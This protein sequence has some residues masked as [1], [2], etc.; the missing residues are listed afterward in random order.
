MIIYPRRGVTIAAVLFTTP[1]RLS[2]PGLFV[3]ATDTG[4]GKTVVTCAIA[5]CLQRRI[6]RVGV[7]KP[8]ATGCRQDDRGQLVSDDA[9]AL[10]HFA[11]CQ[12]PLDTINPIRYA[13]PLAP[14]VAAQQTGILP[15]PDSIIHSLETIDAHSDVVLVEGIGGL[16]VPLDDTHTVLDLVS[17]LAYPVVVVTRAGLGTLN[18]TAMTVRLLRQSACRIAGLVVN[19]DDSDRPDQSDPSQPTNRQWLARMNQ[20]LILATIPACGPAAGV[21]PSQGRI[22][23]AILQAVGVPHWPDIVSVPGRPNSGR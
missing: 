11:G 6:G 7:C 2:K 3:T 16:L 14:A 20:T 13:Q 4:V 18:H 1:P 12:E 8:F 21:Q 5:H 10:A 22:P 19:G 17:W 15:D 9:L 23:Q